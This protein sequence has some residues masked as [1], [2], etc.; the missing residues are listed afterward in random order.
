[1]GLMLFYIFITNLDDESKYTLI[2]FTNDSKL[3][4]AVDIQKGSAT[5]QEDL[6]MLEE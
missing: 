3:D 2:K 5:T 1:M 6:R 4:D